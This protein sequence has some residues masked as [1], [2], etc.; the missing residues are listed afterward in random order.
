MLLGRE[1]VCRTSALRLAEDEPGLAV[2]VTAHLV[3]ALARGEIGE[4]R[5]ARRCLLDAARLNV[6][7]QSNP[8]L[9]PPS[10]PIQ[11]TNCHGQP[12]TTWTELKGFSTAAS[13][14]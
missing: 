8:R 6:A 1:S 9:A 12:I 13:R 5:Q 4:I 2:L 14:W 10:R 11:V 3:G 7:R